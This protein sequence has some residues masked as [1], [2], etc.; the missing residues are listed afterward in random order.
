MIPG[1][2]QATKVDVVPSG[3]G[4]EEVGE[5]DGKKFYRKVTKSE[6][7]KITPSKPK[8]P[9]TQKINVSRDIKNLTSTRKIRP[10]APK[11][12][13]EPKTKEEFVYTE[14]KQETP[15]P[16]KGPTPKKSYF[17]EHIFDP[18]GHAFGAIARLHRDTKDGD[19]ETGF[20]EPNNEIFIKYKPNTAELDWEKVYV[21]PKGLFGNKIT[22][23]TI[24]IQSQDA[25]DLLE[26]YRVDPK[27]I[28][29]F[30]KNIIFSG[31]L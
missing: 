6:S 24:K 2:E 20:V 17:A 22:A 26:K 9:P 1:I 4:W 28:E 5:Q 10:Q 27:T 14:S 31:H 21:L 13:T 7:V 23:G 16:P 8:A 12:V 15:P 29:N 3:A 18:R 11:S 30:S 19:K 25:I